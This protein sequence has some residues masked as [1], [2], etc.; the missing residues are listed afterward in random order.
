MLC[1]ARATAVGL[2]AGSVR[3]GRASADF[4]SSGLQAV[5]VLVTGRGGIFLIPSAAA[6]SAC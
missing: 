5:Y 2:D 3:E 6:E 4:P 1:S